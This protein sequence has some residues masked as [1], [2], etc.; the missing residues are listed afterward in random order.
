MK[1][2][3]AETGK[4]KH[5]PPVHRASAACLCLVL[6]CVFIASAAQLPQEC[7]PPAFAVKAIHDDPSAKV[8]DATGAWFAE[9]GDLK[10]AVS[11]F[12]EAVR[13]E[14]GSSEAHYDLAV[15]RV[16]LNQ[17]PA[18]AE[19]FRLALEGKPDMMLAHMALGSALSDMSKPAEAEAEFREA[20]R[21]DPKSVAAMDHLAQ[22]LA[23]QR[24]YDSAMRYWNAALALQPES[25]DLLLSLGATA[26]EDA[27]VKEEEGIIGAKDAGT[28]E[29]T[30]IL[31]ELIRLHPDMK[32]AHFTLGNIY[33]NEARFREAADEYTEVTRLDPKDTVAL[34]ARVKALA[35]VSAFQDALAPAQE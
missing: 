17:L 34:L 8:W 6:A 14:P 10:C 13:L 26:Y 1:I 2:K 3:D 33:A 31:T 29:A 18:A 24:R 21:L 15:A 35:T 20:L 5:A 16:R 4:L 11:A 7:T 30:R 23:A 27:A 22:A 9:K 19:Q 28:K 12:E 25:P 32:D